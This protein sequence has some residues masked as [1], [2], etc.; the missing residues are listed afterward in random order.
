[1]RKQFQNGDNESGDK[2]IT[3]RIEGKPKKGDKSPG[4]GKA[5]GMVE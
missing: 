5:D 2:S 3:S 1:M 4:K